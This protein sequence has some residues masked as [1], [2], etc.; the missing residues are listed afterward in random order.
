MLTP[1]LDGYKSLLIEE[2]GGTA[3]ELVSEENG[4][5]ISMLLRQYFMSLKVLDR[6]AHLGPHMSNHWDKVVSNVTKSHPC[7]PP[8]N[9]PPTASSPTTAT[10]ATPSTGNSKGHGHKS[11]W[12][13]WTPAK[14]RAR[15]SSVGPLSERETDV[16]RETPPPLSPAADADASEKKV[17]ALGE[18]SEDE[19]EEDEERELRV[20]RKAF[21]R[22]CRKA[23]VQAQAGGELD[24]ED[25]DCDWTR[26]IAPKV[27]GRI[28]MVG[29]GS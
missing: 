19:R 16:D 26:A 4:I 17:A 3:I 23:G 5:L 11:S 10:T 9:K 25:V 28:N 27:E 1:D 24:E 15:R 8:K 13:H 14:I 20:M 6:W 21:R 29:E 7:L 2:E 12:D 18:I 22:W